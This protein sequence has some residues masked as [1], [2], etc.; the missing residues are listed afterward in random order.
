MHEVQVNVQD[1]RGIRLLDD[2]VGI[3]EF[4]EEGLGIGGFG[5]SV[6]RLSGY[7]VIRLFGYPVVRL[8]SGAVIRL[9]GRG[10]F[11]QVPAFG[12][13]LRFGEGVE[14]RRG[15]DFKLFL[16]SSRGVHGILRGIEDWRLE[17]EDWRLK[18]WRLEIEDW[19]LKIGD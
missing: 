2:D 11:A 16:G 9:G 15:E 4:L 19:R 13:G 12:H 17:I 5:Y 3:P 10:Q 18:N 7:P 6:G 1:G 14:H 8:G